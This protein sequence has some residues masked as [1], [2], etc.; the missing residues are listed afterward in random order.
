MKALVTGVTGQDGAYLCKLLVEKGYK[1]YGGVRRTSSAEYWR[2][3]T[4][5]IFR[6]IEL[7]GLELAEESNVSGIIKK[8]QVDEIY[9]LAAQSFVGASFEQPVYTGQIDGIAVCRILEAIRSTGRGTKFYQA[10]TSEMFGKT[11]ETPQTERTPFHPRSP[12][13]VAKLYAHWITVNYREAYGLF[14]CSGILF[15]H[16]SPLR[17]PEFLTRKTTMGLA[18][19]RHG[20]RDVLRLG[21][22]SAQR[23]WGHAED[24]VEGMWR[25]LQAPQ[26]D[27]YVLA[28]GQTWTV[29]EFVRRAA[30][31]LGF[32]LRWEGSAEQEKGIDRKTN[33]VIVEVDPQFYRPAEVDLLVGNSKKAKERLGWKPQTSFDELVDQMARADNDRIVAQGI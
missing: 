13:G 3:K 10:S 19:I 29:R 30:E 18:E 8:L 23:D 22:L 11:V 5:D 32:D 6:E 16:E 28:T 14:T 25:M 26:P 24:Y 4:L 31:C 1:V 2:L 20:K 9:N 27:D 21:N 12:Y 7:V 33:S 17:G 15:N